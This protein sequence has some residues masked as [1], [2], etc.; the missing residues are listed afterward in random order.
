[1][2]PLPNLHDHTLKLLKERKNLLAF[3]GGIDSSALFFLLLEHHI[4]FD[5]ALINYQTRT[6]SDVE[7]AHARALAKSY[8]KACFVLTCKLESADFEHRARLTRYTFFEEIITTHHYDTLL[9]AHHLGD[10]LEWFL[11]QLGRGAGLVEMLGMQEIEKREHYVLVRPL[12]HV[13]KSSLLHFLKTQKHPYFIDHSNESTHHLRNL[14][15]KN[16]A[17]PL[18]EAFEEGIG[19]SFSY[20]E[21]DAKRLLPQSSKRI[22]ELFIMEK[23]EDDLV[24]IR[25][26]D[27]ALKLLGKLISHET[28]GEI[29][30]TQDCV[31]GGTFAVCFGQFHIFVAPFVKAKMDKVFKEACRKALIPAKIRPYMYQEKI[32]VLAL[33]LNHKP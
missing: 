29:L 15:R 17:N 13:T 26:I 21:E 22:K 8:D 18:L 25:Q 20:L 2:Q 28:R 32:S 9:T 30:R 6:Q 27:K 5:I 14:I 31:V 12:L 24:N 10:R 1:M 16:Y 23:H 3:S 11:M 4:P 33:N 7:E 19:K